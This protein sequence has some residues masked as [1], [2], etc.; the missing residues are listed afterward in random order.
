MSAINSKI[1][2][3]VNLGGWLLMEGY[4]LHGRNIGESTW[5]Q[6]FRDVCGEQE[7]TELEKR[8]RDNFIREDDF[9]NIAAMGATAV[10][11]PFNAKLVEKEP[12]CYSEEGLRY[13]DQALDWGARHGV[14]VILDLHA[15]PG[16]QNHDWH[17]D[18]IGGRALFWEKAECIERTY[19]IWETIAERF[20][21]KEALVGYDLLNEPVLDKKKL[22][23]LR[24]FYRTAIRRI[25]KHDPR[26]PLYVEG[27]NWAQDIDFLAEV[28]DDN[29]AVSIHAYQPISYTFNLTPLQSYPGD[30]EGAR[31]DRDTLRRSLERYADF[32]RTHR[33]KI[34]VGEFGV[35]WR[36]GFFGEERW[37]DDML[38]V[39]DE[40]G[41]D[42]TYWTYKAVANAV[43]PD[44]IYQYIPNN[45]YVRRDGPI[46]GFENYRDYWSEE[47]D[48]LAEFWRTESYTP[49]RKIIGTL[50]KHFVQYN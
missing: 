37:L 1:V 48:G 23:I 50:Q 26:H 46:Y 27:N 9:R 29:V 41:F 12:F 36:G 8:Y 11:L 44:G 31:W 25:R 22:P 7:L 10:R 42:Y 5:K 33:V 28:L 30:I 17:S 4:I 14:G 3:G 15:A 20:K 18:S 21:D 49:N 32:G 2:R 16:A 38:T 40:F 43:F 34:F 6:S 35:N 45:K 39:Y 47:K 19:G 13:L 24:D